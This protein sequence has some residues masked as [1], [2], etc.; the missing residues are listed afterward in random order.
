VLLLAEDG[1]YQWSFL[2]LIN[3]TRERGRETRG[4]MG[5]AGEGKPFCEE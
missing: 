1:L 4:S 2:S 3:K 5:Y